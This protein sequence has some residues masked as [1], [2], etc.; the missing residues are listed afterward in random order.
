MNEQ[1]E[2]EVNALV[3]NGW[4]YRTAIKYVMLGTPPGHLRLYSQKVMKP[5]LKAV[6]AYEKQ[7]GITQAV[8]A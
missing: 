8:P 5:F 3:A 4:H 2:R 6:K 1:Q 7:H